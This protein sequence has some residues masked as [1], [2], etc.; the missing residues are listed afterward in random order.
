MG[1][2]SRK[3][4]E[5]LDR[6]SAANSTALKDQQGPRQWM[7][8]GLTRLDIGN[9]EGTHWCGSTIGRAAVWKGA[10]LNDAQMRE[11]SAL[12]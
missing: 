9:L 6:V 12:C 4:S 8:V 11:I 5:P 2:S 7:P 10:P 3:W 1:S